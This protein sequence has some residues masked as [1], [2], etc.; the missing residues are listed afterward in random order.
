MNLTIQNR[1]L[2][3]IFR[4][5][6][7]ESHPVNDFLVPF[8]QHWSMTIPKLARLDT[9]KTQASVPRRGRSRGIPPALEPYQI[10]SSA[11]IREAE[12]CFEQILGKHR[13]IIQARETSEFHATLHATRLRDITFGYLDYRVVA[14]V[15]CEEPPRDHFFIF[16]PTSGSAEFR[17]PGKTVTTSMATAFV[18]PPQ[19][20]L[21]FRFDADSPHLFVRISKALIERQLTH[22]IGRSLRSEV[23]FE[24]ELDQFAP[25]STRWLSA[26]YL[27]HEELAL[28]SRLAPAD[29]A[30]TA[31]ENYVVSMLLLV[32][33]SN[34][35]R[36][37]QSPEQ[38]PASRTLRRALE[39][40]ESHLS[41]EIAVADVAEA[42]GCSIRTLQNAFAIELNTSAIS[43]IRDERLL[44][45]RESLIE[46]A[47]NSS[48]TRSCVSDTA[49]VW[50]F[51]HMGH[52]ASAYRARFNELP[53]ETIA[54]SY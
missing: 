11:F 8:A 20:P 48:V 34:Y 32:Q 38:T 13:L 33:P 44:R 35:T 19:E 43:Y 1:H 39:F 15:T 28:P 31:L 47:E 5:E 41:E 27:L 16:M 26:V 4:N 52:F 22:M 7:K 14:D 51:T 25:N 50:G 49:R 46:A 53:S 17:L 12:Q 24:P 54:R 30:L 21:S 6:F 2:A 29:S 3:A 42:A 45:V 23:V 36:M 9:S 37:L 18:A 10:C 40:I